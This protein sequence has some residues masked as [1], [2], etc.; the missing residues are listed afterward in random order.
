MGKLFGT[1]GIR[2]VVNAGLDA[3]LAY[4]VGLAAAQVLARE[5]HG[6]PLVTIG[7]DTRISSDLLEGALIA[8]LCSAGAD[9]LHLGVIP[10]PGV[11][12]ITVDRGADAGIVISASHNP[13]EHNGIKIFDGRGFKLSDA[14]EE[15]IEEIILGH[16][17]V[18]LKTHGDLGQVI[19]ADER[20]R[21]DYIDHLASTVDADLSGLRIL[22]DCANGASSATAARLFDRFPKLH[23]DIINADP[24]GVNINAGCGSTHL[25]SLCTM[26]KAGGYDLGLAFDGDADRCLA[27]DELGADI[28]GDQIMAVCGRDLK[29]RGELPGDAVVATVMSNLGLHVFCRENGLQL[30][31]TDVGD[32][33]VLEKMEEQGYVLGGEQ[34]GHMIFRRFATTGDGQ[35]TALQLLN[36]LHKSGKKASQLTGDC[37]R[38]PQVLVNVPVADKEKKTAIMA[39]ERLKAAVAEREA[40]LNGDG[41]ILVRPSGTEALIRVMVEAR[42]EHTAAN[43]ANELAELIKLL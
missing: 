15:E 34:S 28:D 8:G 25:D 24:D 6:K 5:K 27:C 22:V 3:A 17:E 36:L 7:K 43:C 40:A 30:L 20:E 10:T 21:D 38:Y 2:G 23:T 37:R 33:N 12:W 31:C 14:L 18:P 35:L 26:V 39:S 41:R 13:F 16:V 9:V 42:E 29:N 1:D 32:R 19:Y 11:A 4:Q